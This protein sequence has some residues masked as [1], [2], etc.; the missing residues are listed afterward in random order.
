MLGIFSFL[1]ADKIVGS[2]PALNDIAIP[3]D[4]NVMV[5]FISD[6]SFFR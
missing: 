5:P 3:Y 6:G 1:S 4:G 2:V